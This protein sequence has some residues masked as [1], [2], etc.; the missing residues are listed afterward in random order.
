M[1]EYKVTRREDVQRMVQMVYRLDKFLTDP[2]NAAPNAPGVADAMQQ[3]RS[4]VD[5]LGRDPAPDTNLKPGMQL[6]DYWGNFEKQG[7]VNVGQPPDDP[8]RP[9]F[10][11]I[12]RRP[13]GLNEQGQNP[14]GYIINPDAYQYGGKQG[15]AQQEQ[16]RYAGLSAASQAEREKYAQQF[17]GGMDLS[18][19]SR[20]NQLQ[21][22]GYLRGVA[23][24]TGPSAAEGQ[25]A[26]GLAQAR[27]Q[28]GS[29]AASARGG[30]GNL[31][32]AQAASANAASGLSMQ[33]IQGAAQ[34]RSQE[35]LGAMSQYG[36][37]AG[38]MREGDF[39]TARL[40]ATQQAGAGAQ[41]AQWDAAR[42]G[43]MAQQSGYQQAA[44]A[45]NLAREGAI[46]GW[47]VA[48]QQ[49]QAAQQAQW[50]NA[51]AGAVGGLG[52]LANAFQ[53]KPKPGTP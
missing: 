24:G 11:S 10:P 35:Q 18:G 36:Q 41:M 45:Q 33:G 14:Y 43:V 5:A 39:D 46:R 52:S 15:M 32:A 4:I 3:R 17:Q 50:I 34:L 19:Q 7:G 26:R 1:P 12:G 48:Q 9:P 22:L 16:E 2:L 13:V 47:E 40:Y 20:A 21:G 37:L 31:A 6:G 49:Q 29:I 23:E 27:E 44:E 25:M 42:Q 28:Q 30:G 38:Q 8:N 53:P 51:F